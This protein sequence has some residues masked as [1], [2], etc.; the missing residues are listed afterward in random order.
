MTKPDTERPRPS[1]VPRTTAV[2]LIIA[3]GRKTIYADIMN[4]TIS[5]INLPHTG[6]QDIHF[7]SLAGEVILEIPGENNAVK[8]NDRQISL[9]ISFLAKRM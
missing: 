3:P 9:R 8:A 4:K 5:K 7:L 2:T 1:E 6:I